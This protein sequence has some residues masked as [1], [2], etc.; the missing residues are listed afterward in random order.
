MGQLNVLRPRDYSYM[1]LEVNNG[2]QNSTKVE[3]YS[4]GVI[5]QHGKYIKSKSGKGIDMKSITFGLASTKNMNKCTNKDTKLI[6]VSLSAESAKYVSGCADH[7]NLHHV[8][9]FVIHL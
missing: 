2:G 8:S 4:F 1:P 9:K 3:I 6:L 7:D 5:H